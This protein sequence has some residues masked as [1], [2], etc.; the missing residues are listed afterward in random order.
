MPSMPDLLHQLRADFADISFRSSDTF[1]WNANEKTV[2]F[3]E[4]TEDAATYLL[5]ETGHALLSHA[6]YAAD[7]TLL[8]MERDAWQKARQL[9]DQYG[10]VIDDDLVEDALDTYRDWLHRRSTCPTCR[11]V[12]L[13]SGRKSY[14]CLSCLADWN[15]NEARSCRLRRTLQK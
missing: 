4:S 6:D 12:G 8:G 5:H 7:I 10:V 15:V 1:R 2:D 14:H 9:G 11:A 3:D 13:Q